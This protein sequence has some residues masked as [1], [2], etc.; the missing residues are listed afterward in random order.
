MTVYGDGKQTRSFQYVSDLV[1]EEEKLLRE[2]LIPAVEIL[3]FASSQF[4]IYLRA[5]CFQLSLCKLKADL[6]LWT[7]RSKAL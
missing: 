4:N 5:C 3:S 2:I 1:R 7:C 6:V